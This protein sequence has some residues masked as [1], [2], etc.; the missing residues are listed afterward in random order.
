VTIAGPDSGDERVGEPD[1]AG[2]GEH[3][4]GRGPDGG[5]LGRGRWREGREGDDRGEQMCSQGMRHEA[6]TR[7]GASASAGGEQ[8]G[9][10]RGRQ[11]S[12]HLDAGRYP[13]IGR[14]AKVDA[15]SMRAGAVGAGGRC[16][17]IELGV[18]VGA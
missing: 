18:G 17:W 4:V 1:A 12:A 11:K 10:E 2:G 7:V 15:A 3:G 8:R 9:C 16:E 6:K 14:R 13:A 5:P